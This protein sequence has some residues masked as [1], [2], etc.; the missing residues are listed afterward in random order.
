[1]SYSNSFPTQ[2][3]SLN[4]VFNGGSD[5]LDSRISFSRADT[6]PTYAA[7]SAVHYWSNEK[8]LNSENLLPYSNDLSGWSSSTTTTPSTNNLAPDGTNTATAVIENTATSGHNRYKSFSSVSGTNYTFLT[9]A[10]A[11][12]RTRFQVVAQATTSIANVEFDLTAVTSTVISGSAVSHSIMAVGSTGYYKCEVTVTATGTG[13]NAYHQVNLLDAT[14]A[15]SYTGDGTSGLFLWGMQVS[16]TGE[17]VLNATS[18]SIHR[19][20]ASTLKSVTNAGDPRF[21]YD[22]TDGQS[23][24]L[25]IESSAS[26]LQ[27][28]GSAFASWNYK[29]GS[30]L[31]ANAGIAPNGE[32]EATLWTATSSSSNHYLNDNFLSVTSGTTYTS[33][34][35]VKDAGQRYVQIAGGASYFGTGQYATFDLQTGSVD[36]N[37]VTA[38]AVSVGNGWWRIQAT[39]TATATGAGMGFL[40]LADS[41]TSTRVPAF[42]ADDYSGVLIFGYQQEEGSSASSLVNTGSQ[43]SALTRAADSCSVALSDVGITSGQDLTAVVEGDA[44]EIAGAALIGFDD[45]SSSNYARILRH[46]SNNNYTFDVRTN[47]SSQAVITLNSSSTANEFAFRLEQNNIGASAGG[48]AVTTDT[49]ATLG[50]MTT[51]QIGNAYWGTQANGAISRVSIYSAPLTD[52]N[53]TALSS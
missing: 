20:F 47:A 17:T 25:L 30:G 33:S 26:N 27:R 6:P 10:K 22:P 21:E 44:A 19:E 29:I 41:A 18:G 1:M 4:L 39:M 28:Y 15:S 31:T 53:L 46:H 32:L 50:L 38:S 36:A 42:T 48:S 51:M 7:P 37:G 2:R 16:S 24:G 49:S 52:T 23:V 14:G 3:P 40:I 8:A 34:V 11:S 35:Y 13:S 9:F 43:N 45:G 5:Q 12:G